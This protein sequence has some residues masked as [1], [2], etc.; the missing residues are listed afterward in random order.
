M[1]STLTTSAIGFGAVLTSVS[2][3]AGAVVAGVGALFEL[4]LVVG[5]AASSGPIDV[6]R[7]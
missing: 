6:P 1:P 5:R 3:T 7:V 4:F 2:A